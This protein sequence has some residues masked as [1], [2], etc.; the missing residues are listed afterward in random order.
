MHDWLCITAA[1]HEMSGSKPGIALAYGDYVNGTLSGQAR[2]NAHHRCKATDTLPIDSQVARHNRHLSAG[3]IEGWQH[4]G[5]VGVLT[6][7]VT[8]Y[9]SVDVL[10]H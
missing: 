3:L 7:P 9:T 5:A 1:L 2:L 10:R 6:D 4:W 8:E